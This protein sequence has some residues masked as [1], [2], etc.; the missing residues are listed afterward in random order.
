MEK[1][2]MMTFY[3]GGNVEKGNIMMYVFDLL[4]AFLMPM[5]VEWLSHTRFIKP[6]TNNVV[7]GL[8]QT[9]LYSI[10]ITLA[11]FVMLYV[12]SFDV[13]IF[14]LAVAGYTFGFLIFGSRVFNKHESE[15]YQK[16]SDLP[17]L[18]C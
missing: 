12:M 3:R 13:W 18:N 10:R 11:Y 9:S 6:E 16:P 15:L 8:I 4:S 7:A 2:K 17:P 14:V 5:L 1:P